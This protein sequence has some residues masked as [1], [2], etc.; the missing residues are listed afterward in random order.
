MDVGLL[1][2]SCA[3]ITSVFKHIFSIMNEDRTTHPQW[4]ELELPP[5]TTFP[6]KP[7]LAIRQTTSHNGKVR[8]FWLK[9]TRLSFTITDQVTH[10]TLTCGEYSKRSVFTDQQLLHRHITPAVR[11][12]VLL[13]S[14]THM[15]G[16]RR[17]V[18]RT[19]PLDYLNE[20][21]IAVDVILSPK[22][23]WTRPRYKFRFLAPIGDSPTAILTHSEHFWWTPHNSEPGD[24]S[25]HRSFKT[26][27]SFI[28][29]IEKDRNTWCWL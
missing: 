25:E 24:T 10:M 3:S 21:G 22:Q 6:R 17:A 20:K 27:H 12:M 8:R 26:T 19:T 5:S 2:V 7:D 13:E 28:E 15:D 14:I 29:F 18:A 1:L 4:S 9:N 16:V 11:C 23:Q